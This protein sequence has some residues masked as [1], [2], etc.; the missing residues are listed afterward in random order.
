MITNMALE[1]KQ[2]KCMAVCLVLE[3][4]GFVLHT[5]G[6]ATPYWR[7]AH[8]K[9]GSDTQGS[10]DFLIQ[11]FDEG[12]WRRCVN[13]ICSGINIAGRGYFL[14]SYKILYFILYVKNIGFFLHHDGLVND[15]T[16]LNK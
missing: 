10:M 7:T 4:L 3:I 13:G 8:F 9:Y 2:G 16:R 12:L 15:I 14:F 1:D 11:G 6:Y 5:I